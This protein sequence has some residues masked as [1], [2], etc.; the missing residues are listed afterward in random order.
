MMIS[1]RL[2][3]VELQSKVLDR[4]VEIEPL[5]TLGHSL[6]IQVHSGGE[7]EVSG[8]IRS[9]ILKDTVLRSIREIPGVKHVIDGIVAD[10]DLELSV[11]QTLA[12]DERT[13][14]IL[15]G[16][17]SLR[18]HLGTVTLLGKLPPI[19]SRDDLAETVISIKG[20]RAIDDKMSS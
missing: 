13:K 2:S 9:R 8:P 15:P 5:R 4:I 12:T 10:P 7:I 14:G 18:S 17:I 19:V 11:S 3:S 6:E 1:R 20:V 16:E